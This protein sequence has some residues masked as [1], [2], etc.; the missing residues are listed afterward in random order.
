MTASKEASA[1]KRGM[2]LPGGREVG[3]VS[4]FPTK[5]VANL[6]LLVLYIYW[7]TNTFNDFLRL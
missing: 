2:F 7:K 5:R 6:L 3:G 1:Q 4:N